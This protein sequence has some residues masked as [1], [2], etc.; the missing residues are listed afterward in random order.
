MKS[1]SS[2]LHK[3]NFKNKFIDLRSNIIKS[4]NAGIQTSIHYPVALPCS[5]YYKDKY[6]HEKSD[7]PNA[8]NMSVS[9]IS[10]PCGPHMDEN[11]SKF[12]GN[13]V[14]KFDNLI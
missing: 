10:L 6:E 8:Y 11:D 5:L 3:Y 13:E 14:L 1:K 12:V 7:F 2:V 9:T 4:I